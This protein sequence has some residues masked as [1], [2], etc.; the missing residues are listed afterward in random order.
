MANIIFFTMTVL[1]FLK[2]KKET[3]VL[4]RGDSMTHSGT[5]GGME[6]KQRF[7]LCDPFAKTSFKNFIFLDLYST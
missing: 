5:S 7:F 2:M 4:K 6:D 1:K 3:A